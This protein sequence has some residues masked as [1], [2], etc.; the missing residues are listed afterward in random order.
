M[1]S[2]NYLNPY[3]IFNEEDILN[4]ET[5]ESKFNKLLTNEL[6]TCKKCGYNSKGDILDIKNPTYFRL[7]NKITL[8]KI[9]FVIFD[10]LNENDKG[11]VLEL[12]EIEYERR[13]QY[14]E[15]LL[16]VMKERINY[17]NKSFILKSYIFTPQSDHFTTVLLNYQN[18]LMYLKNK[19]NYFYNGDTKNHCL[20]ETDNLNRIFK[21]NIV[22]LGVYVET[23]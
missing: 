19:S 5:I 9:F 6:S 22:Y 18:E 23:I 16:N 21:E 13:K 17:Q 1:A 12:E 20:E 11:S 3:I 4:N 15:L 14:N 7:V 10:L 2:T 8:P